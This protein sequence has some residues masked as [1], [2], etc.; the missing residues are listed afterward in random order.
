[1]LYLI[2]NNVLLN[3]ICVPLNEEFF[4]TEVYRETNC[5]LYMTLV[6]IVAGSEVNDQH[7]LEELG[8]VVDVLGRN[9]LNW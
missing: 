9:K 5:I 7:F 2:L 4:V 8:M 3:V 6:K 1:M